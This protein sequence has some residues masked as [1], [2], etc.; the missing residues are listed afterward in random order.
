MFNL[1]LEGHNTPI[2]RLQNIFSVDLFRCLIL[3]FRIFLGPHAVTLKIMSSSNG[4]YGTKD[5]L[6]RI[7]NWHI[8]KDALSLAKNFNISMEWRV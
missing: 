6:L 4:L 2:N 3:Q 7:M 1:R 8:E 5:M